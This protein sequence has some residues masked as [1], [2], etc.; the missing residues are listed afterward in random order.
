[1]T[2][3]QIVENCVKYNDKKKCF[4]TRYHY[5]DSIGTLYDWNAEISIELEH[6]KVEKYEDK[7][8][9]LNVSLW[10]YYILSTIDKKLLNDCY[11]IL[12]NMIVEKELE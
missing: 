2:P 11:T 1:M 4:T 10:G 12:V 8:F 7:L 9:F 5:Q 6:V 3:K